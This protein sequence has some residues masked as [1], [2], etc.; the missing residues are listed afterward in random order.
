[1]WESRCD[2]RNMVDSAVV[3]RERVSEYFLCVRPRVP[4]TRLHADN[5]Q[6][7]FAVSNPGCSQVEL[8]ALLRYAHRG[9]LVNVFPFDL[10]C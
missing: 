5:T 7:A 10:L 8:L 9:C 6:F 1:M 2:A 4:F 3:E